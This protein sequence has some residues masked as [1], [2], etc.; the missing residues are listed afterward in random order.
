[1]AT[2][3]ISKDV[4]LPSYANDTFIYSGAGNN[5]ALQCKSKY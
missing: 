2:L 5:E 1:M 3:N 4:E